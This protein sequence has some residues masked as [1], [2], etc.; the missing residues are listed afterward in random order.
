LEAQ[1]LG[2]R[3][4]FDTKFDDSGALETALRPLRDR[5]DLVAAA[6]LELELDL[7]ADIALRESIVSPLKAVVAATP[8]LYE[9][10]DSLPPR[11]ALGCACLPDEDALRQLLS[12]VGLT[13]ADLSTIA[14]RS[15]HALLESDPLTAM[16]AFLYA[17]YFAPA[18]TPA[19]GLEHRRLGVEA[20]ER[21]EA[22]GHLDAAE[23]LCALRRLYWFETRLGKDFAYHVLQPGNEADRGAILEKAVVFGRR[24]IELRAEL[25][26]QGGTRDMAGSP[27]EDQHRLVVLLLALGRLEEAR[28]VRLVDEDPLALFR[29]GAS[30]EA[31]LRASDAV[32]AWFEGLGHLEIEQRVPDFLLFSA[33]VLRSAASGAAV[34]LTSV[35][36]Y[37]YLELQVAQAKFR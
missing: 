16:H 2:A 31:V 36:A 11:V 27:G 26:A 14:D 25:I 12:K 35:D 4:T 33:R 24:A 17:Y 20:F 10:L 29:D 18:N 9:M 37:F 3:Q 13:F 21:S 30:T 28:S 15:G 19:T 8:L 23:R 22:S 34:D 7:H 1:R 6:L 5:P 32:T